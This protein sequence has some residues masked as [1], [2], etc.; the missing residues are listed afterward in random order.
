VKKS[1][2][3]LLCLCLIFAGLTCAGRAQT[4]NS[5]PKP[6]DPAAQDQ[7]TPPTPPQTGQP[8]IEAPPEMPKYPDVRMPGERGFWI[9]LTGMA[10]TGHPIFDQGRNS[11]LTTPSLVQMQGQPKIGEGGEVGIAVGAHNA[12]RI[13]YFQTHANGEFYAPND[14]IL[15]SQNYSSGD[16]VTTNYKLQDF[17]VSFD[18]LT[19]PYPVG[20]RRFRLKTLWQVQYVSLKSTFNAP[21]L[22]TT[23]ANGNVLV[24]SNGNP[25]TYVASGTRWFI[26][27]SIGVGMQE[28]VSRHLRLDLEAT[29]FAIPHHTSLWDLDG[30]VNFRVGKIEIGAGARAFHFKT[31]TAGPYYMRGTLY[32]PQ[33]SIRWYSE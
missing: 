12:L 21:L 3:G 27:P 14:L 5:D 30:S 8:H 10:P 2:T 29:G 4:Q 6:A 13:S 1:A 15:W 25:I 19:W 9:G 11:G 22:P 16:L 23:D 17:K 28:Y 33:V 24:D 20:S 18:Y 32:A 7:Q 31:S 26:S